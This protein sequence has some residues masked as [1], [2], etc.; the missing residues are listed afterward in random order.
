MPKFI[1]KYKSIESAIDLC[2]IL[3]LAYNNRIYIPSYTELNDPL[4]GQ[5]TDICV[6]GYAGIGMSRAADE[7]DVVVSSEKEKYKILSLSSNPCSPLLWAN[8]ANDY[9]GICL[10][11]STN[12]SFHSIKKV[13][14]LS[15]TKEC[16]AYTPN[17]IACAV[18]KSFTKKKIDWQYENEWRIIKKTSK[19]YIK[20]KNQELVGIILGHKINE[21]IKDLLCKIFPDK[22]IMKTKVGH[23]TNRILLLPID[24]NYSYDGSFLYSLDI[25]KT[26]SSRKFVFQNL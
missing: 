26:L 12:K 11:F 10:C 19:R 1:Y 18:K 8:Y 22:I 6:L 21:E 4:E 15:S 9:K 20:F 24:C 2:R 3:D 16:S 7:E 14:Y 5:V 17:K 13:K 25:E 23:R